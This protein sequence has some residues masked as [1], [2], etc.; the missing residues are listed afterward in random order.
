ME[1]RITFKWLF[2]VSSTY[3]YLICDGKEQNVYKPRKETSCLTGRMLQHAYD[4][5]LDT[6]ASVENVH[7]FSVSSY[8]IR[9]G[10]YRDS[11]DIRWS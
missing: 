6:C 4:I 8:G 2:S 11:I 7:W 3:F 5:F 9:I 10:D 1:L